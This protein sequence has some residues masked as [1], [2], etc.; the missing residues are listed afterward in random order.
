VAKL[1]EL[2]H[3]YH[4]ELPQAIAAR[5]QPH[6]TLAELVRLAEWKMSRGVW[7]APNLILVRSNDPAAVQAVSAAALALMPHPTK[8][9]A[10]LAKE[11]KGVGPAT[12]SGVV[13]A[14]R[15]AVYPFFDELVAEQLPGLGAVAWTVSYY[16]RYAAALRE[17]AAALGDE[18]TPA[19][20]ER[21]L[22][23]HSGGKASRRR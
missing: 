6:V 2:D 1:A 14:A 23:A 19:S 17:H 21:A 22:W 8:P 11:L 3:W 16:A 20:L 18:W 9:I 10:L 7:R 4:G 13:A 5:R 15:P 12:G